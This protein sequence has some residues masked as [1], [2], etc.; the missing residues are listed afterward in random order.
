[1]KLTRD[2]EKFCDDHPVLYHYTNAQG[3]QGILDNHQLWATDIGYLNDSMER[4]MFFEKRLPFLL[5]SPVRKALVALYQEHQAARDVIAEMGGLEPAIA[6]T[7]RQFAQNIR[8]H[9]MQFGRPFITSF[10]THTPEDSEDG[11]LSQWR[12]Y[13]L[14]GGYALVFETVGLLDLMN[15]EH[16][17][18]GYEHFGVSDAI[19]IGDNADE[20]IADPNVEEMEKQVHDAVHQFLT[21]RSLDSFEIMYAA[22][23]T[24]SCC[25]KH[26]GFSEER[27]VRIVAIPVGDYIYPEVLARGD[28]RPR[29]RICHRVSG[30]VH[31][32][33]IKLFNDADRDR[34][35]LPIKSVIVGPHRERVKR[36]ESVKSLLQAQGYEEVQVS[37]SR[38]PYIGR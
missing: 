25:T 36:R 27:E 8:D 21:T 19:Y 31:V 34:K 23:N 3:L 15:A 9:T 28:K 37:V 26:R 13:G 2:E 10:C 16:A 35:N 5:P 32:P 1:M 17:E 4:T 20:R 30:G 14:D 6:Q 12:G 33:Y 22:I 18:F 38:I 11:L 29:K 7:A 24:L